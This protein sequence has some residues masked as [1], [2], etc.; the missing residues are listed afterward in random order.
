M[1]D[2][3]DRSSPFATGCRA[4]FRL[5]A[6]AAAPKR[7]PWSRFR[8]S[9]DASNRSRRWLSCRAC[10]G[11]FSS[12]PLVFAMVLVGG[13]TRLTE[14]GLSI[15]EWNL[16]TGAVPP[17]CA[18]AWDAAFAALPAEPATRSPESRHEPSGFKT[19]YWWEWAH[20][21]LGRFIG[22]VYIG[23]FLWFAIRRSVPARVIAIL[24]RDRSSCSARRVSSGGSWLP[25]G[26]NPGM[27]AVEP[28]RLALHLTLA[29]LFLA[30]LAA[31]YVRLG[32]A[33][34]EVAGWRGERTAA[35][36]LVVACIPPDRA[37]RAGC[38]T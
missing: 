29:S 36:A 9:S 30:S 7:R 2:S 17:L 24:A 1:R 28:V 8:L 33:E 3:T 37:R 20:R 6:S 27:T 13:A 10:A 22:L 4:R 25:P 5:P 12:S 31:L 34:P 19:I 32:G 16:V 21:E 38:R 14:S 23:G 35:R 18:E 15:T 26:L 11:C